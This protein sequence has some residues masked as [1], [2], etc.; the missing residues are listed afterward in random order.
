MNGVEEAWALL[1][2]CGRLVGAGHG[3]HAALVT[4]G[5]EHLSKIVEVGQLGAQDLVPVGSR[6][7]QWR[8][9]SG[10]AGET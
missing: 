4:H 10:Q 3:H 6:Y 7:M 9:L 8:R 2:R 1:L 5:G